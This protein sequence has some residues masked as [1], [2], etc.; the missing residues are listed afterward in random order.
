MKLF[1]YVPRLPR[2]SRSFGTRSVVLNRRKS[3]KKPPI[4]KTSSSSSAVT[5]HQP[6]RAKLDLLL[7][8]NFSKFIREFNRSLP[9]GKLYLLDLTNHETHGASV[10]SPAPIKTVLPRVPLT[11]HLDL[12][13]FRQDIFYQGYRPL[14]LPVSSE[15]APVR[16]DKTGQG[17]FR[18]T[19]PNMWNNSAVGLERFKEMDNVPY[20][21][22]AK[23]RPFQ[24]PPEPQR[25]KKE[26]DWEE[27]FRKRGFKD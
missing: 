12:R 4:K 15:P 10:G 23:L 1:Y 14:L 7:E 2:L 19:A 22:L 16:F 24:R 8:K 25:K 26:V 20:S 5:I 9:Q 11:S 13:R 17:M 6:K 18:T 27:Y 3:D 21:V